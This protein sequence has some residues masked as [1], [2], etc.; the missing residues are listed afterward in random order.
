MYR[1]LK[2]SRRH[3]KSKLVSEINIT[4]FVDV[5]LVLLIIFMIAAPMMTG[6]IDVNLPKGSKSKKSKPEENPISISIKDD[7]SIFVNK[8]KIKNNDEMIKLLMAKSDNNFQEKIYINGD[9]S[10][11]YGKIMTVIKQ[12][13]Q[14]RFEK[15]I[16]VTDISQ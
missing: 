6:A 3:S 5:L 1:K 12:I 9:K 7:G 16:L 8:F 2:S 14:A 4:P 10:V 15:V 13:N 11:D